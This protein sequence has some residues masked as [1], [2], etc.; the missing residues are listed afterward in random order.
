M[1]SVP[2]TATCVPVVGAVIVG[3]PAVPS[4][5]AAAVVPAAG[6]TGSPVPVVPVA[7]L[8]SVALPL[9]CVSAGCGSLRQAM[10]IR[11]T[12]TTITTRRMRDSLRPQAWQKAHQRSGA[13][14]ER[15]GVLDRLE[16]GG[17]GVVVGLH[18]TALR[19]ALTVRD[20][21]RTN[22]HSAIAVRFMWDSFFRFG[23]GRCYNFG[24]SGDEGN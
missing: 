9:V 4:C 8:R 2:V 17:G 12:A 20:T 14:R 19:V 24:S 11:K 1:S 13:G 22:R 10:A 23:C 16:R 7:A 21:K 15:V 6:E 18:R 5:C 3:V